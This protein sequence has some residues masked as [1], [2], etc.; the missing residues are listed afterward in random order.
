MVLLDLVVLDRQVDWNRVSAPGAAGVAG[1]PEG[2]RT[3]RIAAVHEPERARSRRGMYG[4][5][6]GPSCQPSDGASGQ[7]RRNRPPQRARLHHP[8]PRY[9]YK[10]DDPPLRALGGS[11]GRVQLV[12]RDVALPGGMPGE[13][14][15]AYGRLAK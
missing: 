15:S 2:R 12:E 8:S 11:R 9:P 1:G 14:P 4:G 13:A 5:Y 10:L 3:N 6:V 7:H